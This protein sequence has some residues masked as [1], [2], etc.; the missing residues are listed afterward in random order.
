MFYEE[1]GAISFTSLMFSGVLERAS[2]SKNLKRRC[3][4]ILMEFRTLKPLV[5]FA[6]EPILLLHA[7]I[8]VWGVHWGGNIAALIPPHIIPKIVTG[9]YYPDVPLLSNFAICLLYSP[10]RIGAL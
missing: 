2:Y 9:A 8:S 1:S 7:P 3:D 6:T 4:P 10:N 5:T